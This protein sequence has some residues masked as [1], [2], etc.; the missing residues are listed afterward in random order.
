[1]TF[2]TEQPIPDVPAIRRG[3]VEVVDTLKAGWHVTR[4]QYWRLLALT[5]AALVVGNLVPVVLVGP[6][7]CG[8]HL[9]YLARLEGRRPQFDLLLEGFNHF[10]PSLVAA[11]WTHVVLFLTVV[12]PAI[13]F[14][15]GVYRIL[16]SHLGG[17]P[18]FD[19]ALFAYGFAGLLGLSMLAQINILFFLMFA[20]LLIVDRGLSGTRAL[21]VS[22]RAV[23]ANLGG[24]AGLFMLA[25]AIV[26]LLAAA[27]FAAAWMLLSRLNAVI[28]GLLLSLFLTLLSLPPLFGALTVAYRRIF[29][30]QPETPHA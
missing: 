1:M 24:L 8:I 13:F 17:D 30:A 7:L 11:L 22:A 9:C 21:V 19:P 10:V 23:W 15:V 26:L 2:A 29:P 27:P 4:G 25:S 12:P 28:A 14:L 16:S 3:A 18:G 5:L 20:Y 6:A